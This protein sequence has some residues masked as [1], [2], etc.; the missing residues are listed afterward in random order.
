MDRRTG[1]R[2]RDRSRRNTDGSKSFLDNDFVSGQRFQTVTSDN[3]TKCGR[4]EK[5][6]IAFPR[7]AA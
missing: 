4:Q 1:N 6:P 2:Y 7:S 3:D 5:R